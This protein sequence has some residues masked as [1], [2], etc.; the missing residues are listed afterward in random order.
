MRPA[1]TRKRWIAV[2]LTILVI[3]FVWLVASLTS[4]DDSSNGSTEQASATSTVEG[5]SGGVS[6]LQDS[7]DSGPLNDPSI[8]FPEKEPGQT[9]PGLAP[10]PE[11]A[12]K[13]V[14]TPLQKEAVLGNGVSAKVVSVESVEGVA[15]LPGEVS[16]PAL[17]FTLKVT[18]DTKKDVD[19]GTAV[20]TAY[21][22]P[23]DTPAGDLREPG[24]TSLPQTLGAG[25]SVEGVYIFRVPLD[26]RDQVRLDFSY[27]VDVPTVIF[28]GAVS[29]VS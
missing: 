8:T 19:L 27:S 23:E 3:A 15:R 7:E 17:R 4:A 20:V 25:K 21:Y 14:E 29:D 28:E 26:Q 1:S 18:N 2:A 5:G 12:P 6:D 9:A 11:P 22:G 16:G 13:P 24:G 10:S